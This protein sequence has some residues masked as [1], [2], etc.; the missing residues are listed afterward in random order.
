MFGSPLLDVPANR[1]RLISKGPGLS[2]TIS[3][4]ANGAVVP[5]PTL[6]DGSIV[7]RVAGA[8]VPVAVVLKWSLVPCAVFV[9]FSDAW[10]NMPPRVPLNAEVP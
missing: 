6:P 5:M 7:I 2:L 10:T 4:A 8:F 1:V 9:Q 3:R